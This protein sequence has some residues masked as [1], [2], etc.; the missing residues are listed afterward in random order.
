MK[1]PPF[2]IVADRGQLKAFAVER[3]PNRSAMPRLVASMKMDEARERYAEK[4]TDQAG[5]FP[6]GATNGQGN[7]VAERIK[8]EAEGEM[9]SFRTLAREITHLLDMHRPERW[10]FAAPSEI[11]GS[12]LDGLAPELKARLA[13]NLPRDLVNTET[14]AL[15][16]HFDRAE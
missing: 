2:L 13:A 16:P 8:L 11:N 14:A 1:V 4:F 10:A 9:R 5:A 12:I 6:D 3:P 7:S 15:L